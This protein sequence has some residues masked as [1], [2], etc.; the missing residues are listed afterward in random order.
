MHICNRRIRVSFSFAIDVDAVFSKS[1]Y[2][3]FSA[4]ENR[5]VYC[6]SSRSWKAGRGGNLSRRK[7][8]RWDNPVCSCWCWQMALFSKM[9][10]CEEFKHFALYC[11][12]VVQNKSTCAF[13]RCQLEYG[14]MLFAKEKK[15]V[16]ELLPNLV[17]MF[18][19]WLFAASKGLSTC[20]EKKSLR[21][22]M[23]LSCVHH[24]FHHGRLSS[25]CRYKIVTIFT[26]DFA[27]RIK[28]QRTH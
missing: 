26:P 7:R 20:L 24:S 15:T 25:V 8:L 17:E 12:A 22:V 9:G 4:F 10:Y 14:L 2:R 13:R 23:N 19:N 1:V 11:A 21:F 27:N 18:H 16:S 28:Q 6:G 5:L 3:M